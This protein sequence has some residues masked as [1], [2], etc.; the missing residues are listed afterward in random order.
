MD[1]NKKMKDGCLVGEYYIEWEV[2]RNMVGGTRQIIAKVVTDWFNDGYLN[3][4]I[5]DEKRDGVL[6]IR[7]PKSF[8]YVIDECIEACKYIKHNKI[9]RIVQRTS[10]IITNEEILS[11]ENIKEVLAEILKDIESYRSFI[12]EKCEQIQGT[13]CPH[14]TAGFNEAA[15][16]EL[17]RIFD[18]LD[19]LKC[20]IKYFLKELKNVGDID[21]ICGALYALCKQNKMYPYYKLKRILEKYCFKHAYCCIS[22]L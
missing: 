1:S 17:W 18:E 14:T 15:I 2:D 8:Q 10:E 3:H 9:E 13:H 11:H 5:S 16:A 22:E 19:D 20:S 4:F 21:K 12:E 7:V 6:L